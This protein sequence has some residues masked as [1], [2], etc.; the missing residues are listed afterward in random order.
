MMQNQ[1]R[2]KPNQKEIVDDFFRL[3][4]PKDPYQA[5]CRLFRGNSDPGLGAA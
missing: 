2:Q 3:C 1:G 4:S 5:A